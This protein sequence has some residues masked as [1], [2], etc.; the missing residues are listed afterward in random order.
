MKPSTYASSSVFAEPP[1]LMSRTTALSTSFCGADLPPLSESIACSRWRACSISWRSTRSVSALSS[2]NVP[3]YIRIAIRGF[4]ALTAASNSTPK[5]PDASTNPVEAALEAP[6][7]S[8]R[9]SPGA[10]PMSLPFAML[11]GAPLAT[12]RSFTAPAVAARSK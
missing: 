8:T 4:P 2:L 6:L 3:L 10:K 9:L 11:I 1:S 12:S 5:L 7:P